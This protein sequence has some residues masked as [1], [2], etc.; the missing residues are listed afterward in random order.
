MYRPSYTCMRGRSVHRTSSMGWSHSGAHLRPCPAGLLRCL[1]VTQG[2]GYILL[3]QGTQSSVTTRIPADVRRSS[4][5]PLGYST[6]SIG[7]QDTLLKHRDL[8]RKPFS[9]KS[10]ILRDFVHCYNK[11]VVIL[12][13]SLTLIFVNITIS[14]HRI[15]GWGWMNRQTQHREISPTWWTHFC[16]PLIQWQEP[17]CNHNQA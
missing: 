9:L 17:W 2:L 10:V 8:G 5:V 14:Y 15:K 6:T 16:L 11:W 7:R 1:N 4:Q 12:Y 13:I 3:G